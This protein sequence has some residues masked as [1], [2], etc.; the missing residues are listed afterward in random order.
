MSNVWNRLF[1]HNHIAR[2]FLNICLWS[3]SI[4]T[5]MQFYFFG[6]NFYTEINRFCVVFSNF[7]FVWITHQKQKKILYWNVSIQDNFKSFSNKIHICKI[8]YLINW[9]IFQYHFKNR[10]SF[11]R[12]WRNSK[13]T[14]K[15]ML[16]IIT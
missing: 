4:F 2:F 16:I 6:T 5:C 1:L 9:T 10:F 12:S 13:T 8:K 11:K 15:T 3:F 7:Q 14:N